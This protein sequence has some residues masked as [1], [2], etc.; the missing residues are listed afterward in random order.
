MQMACG[1]NRAPET[2]ANLHFYSQYF[3][4]RLYI[5]ILYVN[6]ECHLIYVKI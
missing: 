4:I 6:K 3:N 5:S 1:T 2:K